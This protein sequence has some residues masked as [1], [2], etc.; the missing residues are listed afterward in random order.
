M[1]AKSLSLK[2][3][4]AISNA[5]SFVPMVIFILAI[6]VYPM[7]SAV[8]HSFTKWNGITAT[9]IGIQNY[10]DLVSDAQFWKLLMNNFIYMLSVPIQIVMALVI[11]FFLYE[12]VAGYRFF[13]ALF[14]LPN[15]LS[16]IVIGLLFRQAFLYDGP[17]NMVLRSMHL[18]FLALDWL[19]NAFPAMSV[20]NLSVIWT[21]FGYGVIIFFAGMTTI[22]PSIF[23]AA[24]L[25]G[26]S[27]RQVIFSIVLP[28]LTR[29]NEFFSVTTI[30]WIFTGLFGYIY[31]I[32]AGGPGYDTTP[33]EFMIYLKAFKAGGQMGSACALA[34]IL[35]GL[36]FGISRL[37]MIAS[38]KADAWEGE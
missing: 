36:T 19:S 27:R 1:R 13:R 26:A 37:Q 2:K 10:V 28:M 33:I 12:K 4:D 7:Y 24:K 11:A 9:F 6:S 16:A 34:V 22:S 35:L 17:V 29:V 32:T 23:E 31:S 38:K 8:Y 14:F 20:I 30:L 18:D 25:D 5:L 3:R 15:V 21:N